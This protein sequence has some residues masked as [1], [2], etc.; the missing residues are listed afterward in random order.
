[1]TDVGS[2]ASTERLDAAEI[3]DWVY[4]RI[5]IPGKDELVQRVVAGL[6]SRLGSQVR[7]FQMSTYSDGVVLCGQVKTYYGKQ[8]AQEVVLE[9]SGCSVLAN[10]I[11]VRCIDIGTTPSAD[12]TTGH[13]SH[14]P[15]LKL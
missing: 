8:V 11:E 5:E 13:G 12:D 6:Q 10:N 3:P 4:R 7:N 2:R 14:N 1:M 15:E 9:L